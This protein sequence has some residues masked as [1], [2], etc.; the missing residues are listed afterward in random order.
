MISLSATSLN[1]KPNSREMN[2]S[3][4]KSSC[5]LVKKKP[6]NNQQ[7]KN[8]KPTLIPTF[9]LMNGNKNSLDSL[10]F[11]C[12]VLCYCCL[13]LFGLVSFVVVGMFCLDFGGFVLLLLLFCFCCLFLN[14]QFV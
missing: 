11:V 2:M 14:I 6:T 13:F 10:F 8:K 9:K 5:I 7:Q 1:V 3:L 12:F 4:S